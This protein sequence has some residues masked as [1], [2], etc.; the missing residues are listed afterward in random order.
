MFGDAPAISIDVAQRRAAWR[1][2][3][4][5]GGTA[6]VGAYDAMAMAAL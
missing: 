3:F 1:I 4:P 5:H 6:R 2:R